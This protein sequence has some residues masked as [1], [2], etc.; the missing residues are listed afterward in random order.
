MAQF[1]QISQTCCVYLAMLIHMGHILFWF[2]F[3]CFSTLQRKDR[4][5]PASSEKSP[6]EPGR[7]LYFFSLSW[8]LQPVSSFKQDRSHA[9]MVE[10]K[11]Q[12]A[13]QGWQRE[14]MKSILH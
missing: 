6:V 1:F 3:V 8:L 14:L 12:E 13:N 2:F 11:S 10:K 4:I 7:L 9:E 5:N